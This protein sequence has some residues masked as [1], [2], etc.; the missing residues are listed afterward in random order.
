M[1][2]E[3]N[4]EQGYCNIE[5]GVTEVLVVKVCRQSREKKAK[6]KTK[7]RDDTTSGES[8]SITRILL[9]TLLTGCRGIG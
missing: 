6:S 3:R 1:V 4:K 7:F 2:D 9:V 5:E 8:L